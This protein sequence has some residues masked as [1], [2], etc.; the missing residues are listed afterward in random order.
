MSVLDRILIVDDEVRALEA[1]SRT[2]DTDFEVLA[3]RNTEEAFRLLEEYRIKVILCDNRMPGTSGVAFLAEVRR[4]WPSPIRL[5][6]SAYSD[7]DDIIEGV[8][9]GG[10]YQFIAKPWHPSNLLLIIKNLVKLYDLQAENALLASETRATTEQVEHSNRQTKK[11]L[12]Q[13]FQLDSIFRCQNSPLNH[14]CEQ[15]TQ[16]APFDVSVLITGESG[17]GKEMFARALHYGSH[18]AERPF[19]AENCAAL[20]D[21]FLIS[22]LFGH[23]KGAF[24]GAV[25]EHIGLLE[26][27]DGG[28]VFLDEIG[29]VTPSFQVKLLRVLQEGELRPLGSNKSRQVNIRIVAATNRNLEEEVRAGRFRADLY[30]RLATVNINLAPLRQR[31]DDIELIANYLLN[32]LAISFGK[33]I[34]GFSK[35]AMGLMRAFSWP[36]NVRELQNEVKRCLVLAQGKKIEAQDLSPKLRGLVQ[37]PLRGGSL[38]Q[39]VGELERNL[40]EEAIRK[41]GNHKSK[42]ATELGLSRVGLRNKLLRYQIEIADQGSSLD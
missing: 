15:L 2:L 28:T 30:Y 25:S 27:A 21:E 37:A 9:N 19:V 29:D 12:A 34:S 36:G 11:K 38:A 35:E 41:H 40:I 10:I 4:R 5:L 32:S 39:Q 23:V 31:P 18:R 20:S 22:E 13:R 8:N 24:T 7:V 42:I 17:T 6:I 3:A 33:K 16:V 14:A 26:Q 1:M